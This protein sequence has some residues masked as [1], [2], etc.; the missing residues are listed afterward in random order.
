MDPAGSLIVRIGRKSSSSKVRRKIGDP[1]YEPF[2][3]AIGT[4]TIL[5]L[6]STSGDG[7]EGGHSQ[8]SWSREAKVAQWP[9]KEL[10]IRDVDRRR[11]E[12]GNLV[13]YQV[14][15]FERP[16][17]RRGEKKFEE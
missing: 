13:G 1:I 17:E 2:I 12:C 3:L 5:S 15:V 11:G 9:E 10:L 6:L 8:S 16:A 14:Q 4:R 7:F